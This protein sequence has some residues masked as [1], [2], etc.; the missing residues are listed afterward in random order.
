MSRRVLGHFKPGDAFGFDQLVL[1]LLAHN[2][3]VERILHTGQRLD[4]GR[5]EDYEAAQNDPR[6]GRP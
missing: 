4:I 1:S 5:L 3:P 2:R 6:W